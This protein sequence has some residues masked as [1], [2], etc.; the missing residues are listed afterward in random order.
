MN[1]PNLLNRKFGIPGV[2]TFD[3]GNGL[4]R[5]VIRTASAEAEIYLHGAQVTKFNPQNQPPVLFLS[6]LSQ[7]KPGKAIRGGV[8]LCFPWFGAKAGDPKA[9]AHGFARL[10]EWNLESVI[11]EHA[12]ISIVMSLQS[13]AETKALWPAEFSAKYTVTVGAQLQLAL[14]VTNT[15]T[16]PSTYEEAMH[17]YFTVGDIESVSIEGL[18]GT[19]YLDRM[20]ALAPTPQGEDPI[21]FSGETDRVYLGTEAT[22][23]VN[24]PALGRKIQIAKKGSRSTV[25]WNPWIEKSKGFADFGDH[26]WP[27]MVCV[28]TCNVTDYAV[29]LAPGAT[30]T[31]T[32]IISATL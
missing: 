31:M 9:P 23:I 15:G 19:T 20:N 2:V 17:S 14:A 29:E 18:A 26:E 16:T 21:Q 7:F 3:A 6:A 32:A 12:G 10:T 11:Q 24:D 28:E 27:G 5:L 1:D 22:C 8:P 4:T 25:V 30:H 13:S